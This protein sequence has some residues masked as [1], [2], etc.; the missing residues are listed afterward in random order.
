LADGIAAGGGCHDE[1]ARELMMRLFVDTIS[2]VAFGIETNVVRHP[3]TEFHL[4]AQRS[5]APSN[6]LRFLLSIFVTQVL[7]L[8]RIR[9]GV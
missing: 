1:D 8:F 5:V 3:H 9:S 7:T 4:A 2:S 6:N